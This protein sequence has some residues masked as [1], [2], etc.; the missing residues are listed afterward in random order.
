MSAGK[1]ALLEK[2]STAN[3]RQARAL[4]DAASAKGVVLLE[5]FHYRFHP[6]IRRA[7]EIVQSGELGVVQRIECCALVLDVLPHD[8]IQ[9]DY[10][11]HIAR[12]FNL[13]HIVLLPYLEHE[14]ATCKRGWCR[15]SDCTMVQLRT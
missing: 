10:S 1:H 7:V 12:C 5:A 8:N 6:A 11:L 13:H 4:V 14:A 15:S 9:F 3:A 2:P